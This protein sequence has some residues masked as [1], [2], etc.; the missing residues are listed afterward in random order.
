MLLKNP[1]MSNWYF[2]SFIAKQYDEIDRKK[3][4]KPTS[5]FE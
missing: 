1:D 2:T 3:S 4:F 5:S